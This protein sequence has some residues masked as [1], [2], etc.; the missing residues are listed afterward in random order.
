MQVSHP[1]IPSI[2]HPPL[3]DLFGVSGV[4]LICFKRRFKHARHY[5]G[6]AK[7][8]GARL[9]AHRNGQGA[10]LLRALNAAGIGYCIVRVWPDAKRGFERQL[11]R[12]KTAL[13]HCPLCVVERRARIK[14]QMQHRRQGKVDMGAAPTGKVYRG[15]LQ[16]EQRLV[17]VL[18]AS[19]EQQFARSLPLLAG[20]TG[21]PNHSPTGH[22]W[23]YPGSGPAQLAH[24]LL[25]DVFG[26]PIPAGVYQAF[27]EQVIAVLADEWELNEQTV[28]ARALKLFVQLG[29]TQTPSGTGPGG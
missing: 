29:Y 17:L 25:H 11:K 3:D 2:T 20:V 12:S 7:D 28:R 14:I 16:N 23:G 1:D 19:G 10:A 6:W 22:N 8:I 21:C 15:I 13:L 18:G 4:Y 26:T 9:T 27:K 24:D 5:I